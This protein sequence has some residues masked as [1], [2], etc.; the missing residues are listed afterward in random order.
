MPDS[1][2][3]SPT[4]AKR[5]QPAGQTKL[6]FQSP[7]NFL[8]TR[9]PMTMGDDDFQIEGRTLCLPSAGSAPAPG[10][11]AP[12]PFQQQ[13]RAYPAAPAAPAATDHGLAAPDVVTHGPPPLALFDISMDMGYPGHR[14]EYLP[15]LEIPNSQSHQP[16]HNGFALQHDPQD[17]QSL[18]AAL[19][20][21]C[22]DTSESFDSMGD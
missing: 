4:D 6:H 8:P 15:I 2:P 10:V 3:N 21:C 18:E 20:G 19:T 12:H 1:N 7:G 17:L 5:F 11:F 13:I 22:L 9:H 16:P 14:V